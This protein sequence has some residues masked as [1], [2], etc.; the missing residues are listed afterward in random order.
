MDFCFYCGQMAT[1]FCPACGKHLCDKGTC[2]AKAAAQAIRA[3]PAAALRNAPA[4]IG[5]IATAGALGR[6]VN[7]IADAA[8]RALGYK[9]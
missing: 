5:R 3:S 6:A 2:A 8:S 7:S 1:H 9:P 4:A